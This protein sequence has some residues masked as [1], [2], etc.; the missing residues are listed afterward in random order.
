MIKNQLEELKNSKN[1]AYGD[2]IYILPYHMITKKNSF[3]DLKKIIVT[4]VNTDGFNNN[5]CEV[6]GKVISYDNDSFP[7]EDFYS[8]YAIY[9][10]KNGLVVTQ[11]GLYMVT[12]ENDEYSL[13][14][15]EQIKLCYRFKASDDL[16]VDLVISG[17]F[18]FRT[19]K[20]AL[21]LSKK[22]NVKRCLLYIDRIELFLN[23][24][25]VIY[26]DYSIIYRDE[27]YHSENSKKELWEHM[28]H[29]EE[30]IEE[31]EYHMDYSKIFLLEKEGF[32]VKKNSI[33]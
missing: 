8:G 4:S 1:I 3:N 21:D 28:I 7:L 33:I 25:K 18:L 12:Y 10:S 15:N 14:K 11:D 27:T 30:P 31:N 16:Y 24:F 2:E 29:N 13:S 32:L 22:L 19:S 9:R 17:D 26:K 5:G 6:T 23:N 20:E